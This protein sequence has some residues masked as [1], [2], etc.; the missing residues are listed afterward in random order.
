MHRT[1]HHKS[2]NVFFLRWLGNMRFCTVLKIA[3]EKQ[4]WS[5]CVGGLDPY[6][7]TSAVWTSLLSS[8]SSHFPIQH[9]LLGCIYMFIF[10]P[11]IS[12]FLLACLKFVFS[13]CSF[14]CH[15]VFECVQHNNK[16]IQNF[17]FQIIVIVN[18]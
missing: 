12:L 11:R 7:C 16:L 1:H 14:N 2:W 15:F 17:F 13:P 4:N 18:Y 8:S 10:S 5:V 6:C 9:L 3:L